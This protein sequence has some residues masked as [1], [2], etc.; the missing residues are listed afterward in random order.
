M[1]AE[2]TTSTPKDKTEDKKPAPDALSDEELNKITG[3]EHLAPNDPRNPN[4]DGN[5]KIGF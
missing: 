2:P 5:R 4:Y 3:G 1:M